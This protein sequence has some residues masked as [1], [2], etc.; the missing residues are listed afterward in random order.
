MKDLI[1]LVIHDPS[2][3]G[4]WFENVGSSV[5]RVMTFVYSEYVIKSNALHVDMK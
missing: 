5:K 2:F 1:V 3:G 4:V